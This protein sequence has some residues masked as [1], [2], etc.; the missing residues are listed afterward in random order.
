MTLW[1]R[2]FERS[3]DELKTYIHHQSAYGHQIWKDCEL[4]W[5]APTHKVSRPFGHVVLQDHVTK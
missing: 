5:A 2:G 4:H 3:R 1:S